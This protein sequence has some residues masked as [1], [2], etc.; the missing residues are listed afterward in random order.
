MKFTVIACWITL[1][2]ISVAQAQQTGARTT[3]SGVFTA[4]QAKNGE[5]IY[6]TQCAGCHGPKLLATCP[7][8]PD[9]TDEGF[10]SGWLG[11]TV[12]SRF[13]NI[14]VAMPS[15]ATGSLDD[16]T[17]LDIVAFVLQFNG[18]PPGNEKL[19]PDLA[20]L[21]QIVITTR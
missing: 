9:L 18:N 19:V 4:E 20:A 3:S 12:A 6:Q 17:Y 14:R 2:G 5:R 8:A 13:R 1:C 11:K 21:E 10:K 15:D 7:D 16:Q